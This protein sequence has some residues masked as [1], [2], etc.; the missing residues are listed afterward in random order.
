MHICTIFLPS[1]SCHSSIS[2]HPSSTSLSCRYISPASTFS[3]ASKRVSGIIF[4]PSSICQLAG[5]QPF[6]LGSLLAWTTMLFLFNDKNSPEI[7]SK[8]LR[9]KAISPFSSSF[10]EC[11]N[12]T[13]WPNFSSLF[14]RFILYLFIQL[15]VSVK[16]VIL[17]IFPLLL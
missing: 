1:L 13:L 12:L 15:D 9:K 17:Y 2:S 3:L 6:P 16:I 7:I 11:I 5:D 8:Q 4:L 10:L 14:F